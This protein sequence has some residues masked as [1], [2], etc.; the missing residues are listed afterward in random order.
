MKLKIEVVLVSSQL[1]GQEWFQKEM[2]TCFIEQLCM[3]L[4]GK[5]T[6]LE[7]WNPSHF[8][9][10][11][12]IDKFMKV[13]K[14]LL[15]KTCGVYSQV[16]NKRVGW[17]KCEQGNIQKKTDKEIEKL[18][19]NPTLL[20]LFPPYSFIWHLRVAQERCNGF[21]IYYGINIFYR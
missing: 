14:L 2:S 11:K 10:K 9:S 20:A 13:L 3:K 1:Y 7:C 21:I 6:F 18:I 5:K 16:P 19:T 17:K 4:T 12:L 8:L 15:V